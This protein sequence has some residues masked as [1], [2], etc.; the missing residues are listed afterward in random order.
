MSA[1][2]P[3]LRALVAFFA[4]VGTTAFGGGVTAHLLQG[5]L[6]R[7]WMDEATYLEAVN[8]CQNLPGPNATNLSAYLGF[9]FH[10]VP[11]AV[12]ATLALVLPGAVLIL[13]LSGALAQL[14]RQEVV[15][16]AL[17]AVAA[18]AVGLL[19]GMM[20]HLAPAGLGSRLRLA[21]GA[22][23]FAGVAFGGVPTP[24]AIALAVAV[25]WWADAPAA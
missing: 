6:R 11:G 16:G 3:S 21:V 14:P 5:F 13:A 9:Q 8:W 25:M 10:K 20:A 12:L 24:V 19:L 7:G 18:S 4:L 2:R 1:S 17:A 23:V 15:T 22:A